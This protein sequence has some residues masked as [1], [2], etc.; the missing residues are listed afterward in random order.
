MAAIVPADLRLLPGDLVIVRYPADAA[1][2]ETVT[3]WPIDN[4]QWVSLSPEV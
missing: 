3:L 4:Q 1:H 2:H